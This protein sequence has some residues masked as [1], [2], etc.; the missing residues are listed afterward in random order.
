VVP[1]HRSRCGSAAF[2]LQLAAAGGHT[3]TGFD[4]SFPSA[5]RAGQATSPG[6]VVASAGRMIRKRRGARK[7][8]VRLSGAPVAGRCRSSLPATRPD[9]THARYSREDT[10][11][12]L[13]ETGEIALLLELLS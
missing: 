12:Q 5:G 7:R 9:G 3:L 10:S 8:T 1:A 2:F 6:G 13:D 11:A 4:T